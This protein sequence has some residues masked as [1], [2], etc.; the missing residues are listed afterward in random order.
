MLLLAKDPSFLERL[1]ELFLEWQDT[2]KMSDA[3][4]TAVMSTMYKDKGERSDWAMYRP[5]SVTSILYR[6]YGGCLEQKLSL[7]MKRLLGDP[8]IGYQRGRKIDENINLVL[9]IIRYIDNDSPNEG[10]LLLMLDNMKAFDRVQWPFMFA[11]LKAFGF[12]AEYIRAVKVMYED[13]KTVI[14]PTT[15]PL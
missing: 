5:V 8:Q 4:R 14:N 10:G 2:G 6:I 3:C 12:P 15:P 7:V 11:T 1:R 13:V 9:E